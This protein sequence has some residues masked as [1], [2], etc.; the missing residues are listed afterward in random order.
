MANLKEKTIEPETSDIEPKSAVKS[1]V[2]LARLFTQFLQ[3]HVFFRGMMITL[4]EDILCTKAAFR[5]QADLIQIKF[6]VLTVYT[7]F[8]KCQ[9][10]T[11]PHY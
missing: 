1:S 11:W 9:K 7:V 3:R 8:S 4:P 2:M 10:R 5:L 6:L